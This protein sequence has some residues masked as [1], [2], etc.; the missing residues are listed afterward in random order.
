MVRARPER[1]SM[2]VVIFVSIGKACI[3]CVTVLAGGVSNVYIQHLITILMGR[4]TTQGVRG[5]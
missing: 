4:G 5:A 1:V 3:G 2:S